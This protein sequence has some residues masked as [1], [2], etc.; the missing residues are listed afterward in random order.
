M[1]VCDLCEEAFSYLYMDFG[2]FMCR[3]VIAYISIILQ[4][5][6]CEEAFSYL[7]IDFG[8]SMCHV[9]IAYLSMILP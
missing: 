8:I 1:S 9:A 3:I 6:S 7:Y 5:F 2:I 4:W